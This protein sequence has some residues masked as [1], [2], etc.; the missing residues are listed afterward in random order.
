MNFFITNREIIKQNG[1]ETIRENGREH[2]GDNLLFGTYDLIKKE[3]NLFPEPA[4]LPETLYDNLNIKKTVNLKGSALFFKTL[5]DELSKPGKPLKAGEIEKGD[6]LFFIHGFN[7]D[8][9]GVRDDFARLHKKYVENPDSTVKHIMIFTWP[10]R[11]PLIPLHYFDDKKDAIR[12]GEALARGFEKVTAFFK[13]F[14]LKDR[15]PL[16]NRNIHLMA[17]SMGNRV[18]KHVLLELDKK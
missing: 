5:Y 16:C 8:L 10:G 14:F 15:N 1:K 12:S 6:V 3:F 18:L 17:H 9:Q 7:T 2:A 4:N 11:S 13:E